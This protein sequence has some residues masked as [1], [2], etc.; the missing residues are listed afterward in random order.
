MTVK[1]QRVFAVIERLSDHYQ[2]NINNRFIRP[3]FSELTLDRDA[4]EKVENLAGF[5]AYDQM[6]G[7]RLEDLYD[8]IYSAALFVHKVR[9]ELLP[10]LGRVLGKI[11]VNGND[12]IIRDMTVNNFQ[13]NIGVL[14]DILNELYLKTIEVD[15]EL[16]P[17]PVFKRIKELADVGRYLAS[18]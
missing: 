8:M 16:N 7:Y 3:A 9:Q 4:W 18:Q 6:Q 14:S 11:P 2:N 12:R 17:R 10:Q 13:S 1:D 5:S 15:K